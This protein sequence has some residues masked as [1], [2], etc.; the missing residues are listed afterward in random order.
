[1][2]IGQ[3]ISH[4]KILEKLGAGGMGVVYKAED[5]KLK[6]F[7]ALKFLPTELTRDEEAKARFVHEAQAA[8]ALDHPN[9]YTIH[10]INMTDDGQMFIVMA[11]YEGET[12][13][14]KLARSKAFLEHKL[15]VLE[16]VEIA[17]QIAQGLA[18]AHTH[19]IVHRDLKPANVMMTKNGLVKIVDFGLAKLADQPRLT[20]TGSTL[21]TMAYMSPE[22]A[23]G[24]EVDHR[25]DIWAWGVVLY[26]MIT[27]QLPFMEKYEHAM[28]FAILN[29]APLPM[30][31]LCTNVPAQL[32]QVVTKALTKNREQRYQNIE[33]AIRDLA[34]QRSATTIP[35][36][37][38]QVTGS[39]VAMLQRLAVLPFADIR[40]DP[41]TEFLGFALA[42]QIIGALA[43]FKNVMVRPSNAIRPYQNRWVDAPTAGKELNV[44]FVL[45]GSYLNEAGIIRLN[46]ELVQVPSNDMLW[47]EALE[48][49]FENV[50]KLQDLVA[51]KVVQGLKIQF[52]PSER[53]RVLADVPASPLAYEYYLRSIACLQTVEGHRVAIEL[54][55]KSIQLDST[56]APAF[57][58]LGLRYHWLALEGLKGEEAIKSA[59]EAYLKA[60]SLNGEMISALSNLAKLYTETN[61]IEQAVELLRKVSNLNPNEASAYFA[62]SYV[63]R[64]AGMLDESERACEKALALDP[65]NPTFR[66]LSYIYL[67]LGKYEKVLQVLNSLPEDPY[68]LG[69]K[70]YLFMR[71]GQG[72]Q[73]LACYERILEME[74][75]ET[76]WRLD[77][78]FNR[79]YLQGNKEEALQ[80]VRKHEQAN[81]ADA[82]PW[83]FIAE[84]YALVD[85]KPACIRAL[86]KSVTLGFFNYPFMA[87]D[88]YLDAVRDDP[89]FQQVLA[90]AKTKHDAF[91]TRF[92]SE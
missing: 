50:F 79:A 61:R 53:A 78:M 89:E 22:Q 67:Y 91:K 54:L 43:H 92:F 11:Y 60:L 62:L 77:A 33:T 10:E 4:Y 34:S 37:I 14:Q 1:M 20:K 42:D 73:A 21:G 8:S 25:T 66:S 40:R 81:L 82:E 41:Q 19:G 31:A 55:N 75:T 46:I 29:H 28:M 87:K 63:Y 84:Y 13:Q 76:Y 17:I 49:H 32:E 71:M 59:E 88:S 86:N 83:Y 6:R 39:P 85:D 18:E 56:Y 74:A 5:T 70:G 23:R 38:H 2:L 16:A 7:V 47:R 44:D 24:E 26:E 64:F 58:H 35:K 27:A 80:A 15:Q 45:T 52:A 12:L 36:Q 65:K 90:L 72:A 57:A 30:A 9:I 51:E 69:D 3:T 48:V 68:T